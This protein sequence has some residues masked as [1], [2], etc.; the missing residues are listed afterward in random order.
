MSK[1][2]IRTREQIASLS[3]CL[4][5]QGNKLVFTNGCFDI[6]HAGHTQ[7][8]EDAKA[9]GDIL[10]VGLNS[11]ASVRRLKGANRP[12]VPETERALVLAALESVD[13]VV[14]FED[15]TPWE[16]INLVRPHVLVKGGDWTASDIV[17]SDIVL[18]SGGEVLSLPFRAGLS[19]TN[20]IARIADLAFPK[21][22]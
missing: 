3:E 8:L 22:R 15:D 7:Y 2:K 4:R 17:G 6:L 19:T 13:Y 14:L 18:A 1:D 10:I 16:L 12:I 5:E 21:T 9:L 20:I 11:D